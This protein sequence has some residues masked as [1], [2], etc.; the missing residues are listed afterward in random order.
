MPIRFRILTSTIF[1]KA[2]LLKRSGLLCDGVSPFC[3]SGAD[4]TVPGKY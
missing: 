4:G 3:F 1:C 2:F